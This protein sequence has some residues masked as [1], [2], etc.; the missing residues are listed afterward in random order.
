MKKIEI[1]SLYCVHLSFKTRLIYFWGD[2]SHIKHQCVCWYIIFNIESQYWKW[3]Y[4]YLCKIELSFLNSYEGKK[5][6]AGLYLMA[7][8]SLSIADNLTHCATVLCTKLEKKTCETLQMIGLSNCNRNYGT[9]R[10]CPIS[11][12]LRNVHVVSIFIYS[13][14]FTFLHYFL[15]ICLQWT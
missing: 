6:S 11:T 8:V 2:I 4:N 1:F 5:G 3:L 12:L 7:C 13:M 15:R 14:W 9:I 10:M